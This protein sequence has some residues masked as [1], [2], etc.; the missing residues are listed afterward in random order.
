MPIDETLAALVQRLDKIPGLRPRQGDWNRT[1][2]TLLARTPARRRT[3]MLEYFGKWC[4]RQEEIVLE[5]TLPAT[6]SVQ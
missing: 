3:K 5:E 6:D 2:H 4:Q 1:L